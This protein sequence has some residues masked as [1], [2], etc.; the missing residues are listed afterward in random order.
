MEDGDI[1]GTACCIAYPDAGFGWIGLVGTSPAHQRKGIGRA[2]TERCV[3]I[4]AGHGCASVLDASTSGRPVYEKMGF[5]D[6]GPTAIHEL[7]AR[8]AAPTA[9]RGIAVSGIRAD[10]V[11]DVIALDRDVFGADRS[12][13]IRTLLGQFPERTALVR[14]EAGAAVGYAVGQHAL[15]GALVADDER[16]LGALVVRASTWT[17]REPMRLFVPPESA[18]VDALGR[19]GFEWVRELRHMRLD[20]PTLPLDGTR[21]ASRISLGVG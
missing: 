10:D 3:E 12:V 14:D 1:I 4:L 5:A 7:R 15:L 19:L 6:H 8:P 9:D 17:W 20:L 11:A 16:T 2:V 13:V 21:Y 18:Y